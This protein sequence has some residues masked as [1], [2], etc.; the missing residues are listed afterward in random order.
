MSNSKSQLLSLQM[1]RGIAAILVVL[2]H[3]TNLFRENFNINFSYGLFS[4]GYMGVDIF[5]ILSGFLMYYIHHKDLGHR[6]KLTS[7][8][9]KRFIRIY[10]VYW[11]VAGLLSIIYFVA[12]N[13][14]N[15]YYRNPSF[16]IKSLLL[17]PQ[18]HQPILGVAWSL[19]HEVFFYI[20]FAIFIS[21]NK[22][23]SIYI[24][25]FWVSL[26]VVNLFV[27]FNNYLVEFIFSSYNFEFLLGSLIAY[28]IINKR[29]TS[30][31]V[32]IIVSILLL[33]VSWITAFNYNIGPYRLLFWG[34]PSALLLYGLVIRDITL[35]KKTPKFLVFIGDAS[36][37]IYLTH[38]VGL[39][40]LIKLL[41]S[42]NVS[43]STIYYILPV[44]VVIIVT[45]GCFFHI[46]IEKPILR[47]FRKKLNL[48][49]H[50][51]SK[52]S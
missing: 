43:T 46:L 39:L 5:F 1:I 30:A 36:Y 8:I 23:Y 14:G 21:L 32:T 31:K 7:F 47:A 10:P 33:T 37:S 26:T 29:L 51:K 28:L 4:P 18:T 12:P 3:F 44:C 17:V 27:S 9:R 24:F 19:T 35:N 22:K 38:I 41:D 16:I 34:I 49:N 45:A 25:I 6:K 50:F 2:H 11:V 48:V 15:S 20:M 42:I 13:L 52:A 40:F